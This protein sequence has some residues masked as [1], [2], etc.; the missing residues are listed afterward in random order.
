MEMG[1]MV[2]E[3]PTEVRAVVAARVAVA[4][5]DIHIGIRC[6]HGSFF[7]LQQTQPPT[8]NIP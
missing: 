3:D 1:M 7:I 8:T 6:A 4:D 5:A 2:T